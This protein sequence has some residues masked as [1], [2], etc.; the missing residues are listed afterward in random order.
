M[1]S[2]L[3]ESLSGLSELLHKATREAVEATEKDL[4][5]KLAGNFQEATCTLE[6]QVAELTQNIA[7]LTAEGS[8]RDRQLE[9]AHQESK[10]GSI[11]TQKVLGEAA[12]AQFPALFIA[13]LRNT[14]TGGAFTKYY[15]SEDVNVLRSA[16]DMAMSTSNDCCCHYSALLGCGCHYCCCSHYS[17]LRVHSIGVSSTAAAAFSFS[18]AATKSFEVDIAMSAALLSTLTSSEE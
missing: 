2:L 6:A 18:R 4:K 17:V 14:A 3:T 7:R 16:A 5:E 8:Q 1:L 9:M 11:L 12:K 10:E 15:S 13:H